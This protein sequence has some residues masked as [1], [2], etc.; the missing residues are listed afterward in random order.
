MALKRSPTSFFLRQRE[1]IRAWRC[2][3]FQQGMGINGTKRMVFWVTPHHRVSGEGVLV[4]MTMLE[5]SVSI[6]IIHINVSLCH[7]PLM[8]LPLRWIVVDCNLRECKSSGYS[9]RRCFY[10]WAAWPYGH[11]VVGM[12]AK[13]LLSEDMTRKRLFLF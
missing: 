3:F 7:C 13:M 1:G 6:N 10:A 2:H 11:G 8:L 4:W 12:S 5:N 9:P